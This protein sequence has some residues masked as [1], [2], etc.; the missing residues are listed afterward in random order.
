VGPHRSTS[1]HDTVLLCDSD[2]DA[3]HRGHTITLKDGRRLNEH[4]WVQ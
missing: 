1:L 4:G 3:V 2:H